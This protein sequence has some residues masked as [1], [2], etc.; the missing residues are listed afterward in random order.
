M[1]SNTNNNNIITIERKR[2]YIKGL[3]I[4]VVI[5]VVPDDWEP[6]ERL[7]PLSSSIPFQATI[8]CS[9]KNSNIFTKRILKMDITLTNQS[10]G[11]TLLVISKE[12]TIASK[13]SQLVKTKNRINDTLSYHLEIPVNNDTVVE[14]VDIAD[15]NEEVLKAAKVFRLTKIMHNPTDDAYVEAMDQL[16][17]TKERREMGIK[18]KLIEKHLKNIRPQIVVRTV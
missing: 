10:G 15:L 12:Y 5:N 1:S 3:T 16:R 2:F 11:D 8:E 18:R 6:L 7:L 4:D 17:H 9:A 13:V 14:D